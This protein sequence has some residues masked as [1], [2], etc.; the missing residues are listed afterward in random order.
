[1]GTGQ[2]HAPELRLRADPGRL[3]EG[4]RPRDLDILRL[5]S[6]GRTTVMESAIEGASKGA[7]GR[8][9]DSSLGELLRWELGWDEL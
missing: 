7:S 5:R 3:L 9:P 4:E 6:S 2:G 8:S 1:M